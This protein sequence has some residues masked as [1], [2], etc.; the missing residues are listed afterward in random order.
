[1]SCMQASKQVNKEQIRRQTEIHIRSPSSMQWEKFDEVVCCAC[2]TIENIKAFRKKLL[3]HGHCGS[4]FT[5]LL[6]HSFYK[7][8]SKFYRSTTIRISSDFSLPWNCSILSRG[9]LLQTWWI[10]GKATF[11]DTPSFMCCISTLLLTIVSRKWDD[12]YHNQ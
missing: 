8:I 10:R 1:M 4:M 9:E 2:K 11:Y 12:T 6:P 7:L 3:H 5:A